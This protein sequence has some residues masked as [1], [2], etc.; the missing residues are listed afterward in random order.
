MHTYTC[1][2]NPMRAAVFTEYGPPSVV[3]VTNYPIPSPAKNEVRVKVATTA[4][5]AADSRIRAANFPKG[6]GM[7]A[8]LIFGIR[9]P[10]RTVLGAVFAGVVDAVGAEVTDFAVGDRVCGMTGAKFG[11]HADYVCAKVTKVAAIPEPVADDQAAGI[12]FG[13]TTALTYLRDKAAV[14]PGTT[15]LVNGG[16]GAV[17]TN[18]IQLARHYGAH[19]TAVTSTG[20]VQLMRDLGAEQVIDYTTTELKTISNQ[21]DVVFDAVGNIT[22]E[23]GRRMLT[24]DGVLLLA[25]ASLGQTLKA[26]GKVKA[27][28]ASERAADF[29]TLLELAA[30][31]ELRAV[32]DSSYPLADIAAAHA[33]VDTGRKVGNVLVTM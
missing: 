20:N 3:T 29:T 27:G 18:A 24:S 30:R 25:V 11:A 4:V 26:H 2:E 9:A 22:I 13:G 12:L 28:P 8:R 10:R 33:R 1:K 5:T 15:V 23:S 21:F 19:V 16:S 6:F 32:I 7:L 17:G 31:G 14:T